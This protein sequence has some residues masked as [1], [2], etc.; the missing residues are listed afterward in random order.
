MIG[1]GRRGKSSKKALVWVS[2]SPD[3]AQQYC[4]NGSESPADCG[5][6]G[7][8]LDWDS[9]T[10]ECM[11][12]APGKDARR[13]GRKHFGK[14]HD[15]VVRLGPRLKHAG[16]P[17]DG[18]S[19]GIRLANSTWKPTRGQCELRPAQSDLGDAVFDAWL[20]AA[21]FPISSPGISTV[22]LNGSGDYFQFECRYRL[23]H[24]PRGRREMR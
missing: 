8:S 17:F 16:P 12:G 21:M 24:A 23:R 13:N 11:L 7:C 2:S 9:E 19:F 3:G 18:D 15:S 20:I 1:R 22:S 5:P 6:S 10:E 14:L 4:F